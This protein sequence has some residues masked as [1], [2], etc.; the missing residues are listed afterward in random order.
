MKTGVIGL[1]AM[2]AGMAK[3]FLDAGILQAV[4]NRT[5][6]RADQFGRENNVNVAETPADLASGCELIITC[7][8][9]DEDV[10]Q[11]IRQ[12]APGI[13]PGSIVVDTS[14]VSADTARVSA[15]I[16]ENRQA[17]FLD[18]PVSGGIEGARNG[19]LAMMAGG[20][21]AILDRIR[22]SLAAIT[23]KVVHVG[24]TGSG[25]AC[26]AVNQLMCAGI[27]QGVTEAL[28]FGEAMGLDMEKVI[29]V[30]SR[31]AAGNWFLDHRGKSML[32]DRYE[33]GFRV[34]LHDK[35]LRIC[36]NMAKNLTDR[37]LP[38]LEM[39]LIHYERLMQQGYGDEDV[40]ALYR[41]KKG[42]FTD[43]VGQQG[44]TEP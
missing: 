15:E 13:R 3:N 4:W 29:D 38:I 32:E 27:H 18:G 39:T 9:R 44:K 43:A 34:A 7:V 21:S 5:R 11:V 23:S 22:D 16:L 1:G 41:I 6:S 8:S 36:R 2:G 33:P 42:L 17:Y 37:S 19:T 25:Q 14:T 31:G 12:L 26:K 35:D 24:P 20:D 40:S 28:S 30:I 10:L